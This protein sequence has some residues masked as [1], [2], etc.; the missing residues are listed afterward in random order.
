[1]EEDSHEYDGADIEVTYDSNRCIHAREC[2]EGLPAV[3][4]TGRR[5]WV[6]PDEA[7]ADAVA[8]VIERCPTGA[9]HY[10]RLDDGPGEAIP[11]RNTVTVVEDGPLYLHGNIVVETDTA[12]ELLTDTRVGI[13]RCGHSANKPLCD[14]SHDRVFTAD[15]VDA[16]AAVIVDDHTDDATAAPLTVTLTPDGSLRLD[17]SFVLRTTAGEQTDHTAATLCRCG[18]SDDKPHCDGTHAT[19]GFSTGPAE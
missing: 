19:A 13:C 3:F 7:D 18:G 9:L 2:V 1:M 11:G 5:P 12:D 16:D 17:G 8:A 15:G 4:D 10:E 14:N 6:D